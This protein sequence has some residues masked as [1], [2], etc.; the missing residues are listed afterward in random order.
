MSDSGGISRGSAH[1][2]GGSRGGGSPPDKMKISPE[3]GFSFTKTHLATLQT[4][5]SR[6]RVNPVA[7]GKVYEA[8]VI[9]DSFLPGYRHK[10]APHEAGPVK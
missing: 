2:A 10:K 4:D 6:R 5:D 7:P 8:I 3:I 1:T 9:A